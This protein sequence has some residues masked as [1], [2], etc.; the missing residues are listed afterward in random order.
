MVSF[1]GSTR[2]GILVA[3]AA[4]DTVKRVCQELGGKSA[5]IL[6]DDADFAT[7]VPRD[8]L[9]CFSNSGQSCNAPSRMLVPAD[10]VD[11]V[12]RL[13]REAAAQVRAGDP[14]DEATTLGPVVSRR[15]YERIQRLIQSGID[16]G[17]ELV[18]G[19]I[20]RPEGLE[21]GYHVRP[22]VFSGVDNAMT[23]AREEIFGPVVSA[24]EFESLDDLVK[25]ANDT[26]YGLAAGV[27]TKDI[28]KAHYLAKKIRAGTIWVNTYNQFDAASP[29]GGFKESGFGREMGLHALELYTQVKSVWVRVK[30]S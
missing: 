19:G 23:I 11:E 20:G 21:K 28:D 4:A 16:E 17:A 25:R 27:W 29:F 5:N 6:L 12:A 15:Q 2:A 1:T 24:L 7:V 3:R 13:A 8:V 30:P 26:N 18:C 22:T 14:R 10:R 9:H